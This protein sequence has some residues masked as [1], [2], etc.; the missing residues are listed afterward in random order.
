MLLESSY[1]AEQN[2]K[3]LL[4]S[5]NATVVLD[6]VAKFGKHMMLV[7]AGSLSH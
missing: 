3:N 4:A 7:K 5:S 2:D 6:G 1:G